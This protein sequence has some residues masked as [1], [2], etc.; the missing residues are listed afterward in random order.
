V[1]GSESVSHFGWIIVDMK[2][3]REVRRGLVRIGS[4][5]IKAQ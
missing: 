2:Y 5:R 1:Q 4:F 3:V